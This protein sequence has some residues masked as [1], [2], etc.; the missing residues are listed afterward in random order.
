MTITDLMVLVDQTPASQAR[1]GAALG[2]A[3]RFG[4]HLTALCLVAEPFMRSMSRF[5]LPDEVIREH[6]RHAQAEADTV[7][8][9]VAAAAAARAVSFE[10]NCVVGPL[11]RLPTILAHNARNAD[12][13]IV[14]EPDSD[15]SGADEA[16]LVETAFMDTGR[17]ALVV[18]QAGARRL[19]PGRVL[20]AWDGSRE[21]ARAVH[22]GL[23]LLRA[24]EE[25]IVLIADVGR[26]D[27]RF[28]VQPGAGLVAHLG[29]HGVNACVKTVESGG[30]GMAD[31]IL[32]QAGDEQVDLIV[33][34]GYG[35]S[36]LREMMLG[37]VTRR[38]LERM[39]LPV[40]FA[41]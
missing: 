40:L 41:H 3:E 1:V 27:G 37:G 6:L 19:P 31:V 17:P 24:A 26:R 16:L 18:P 10:G 20:V 2:L 14:G 5:H 28:G 23:P 12:L 22:D 29:R 38:M 8:R 9:D 21:A 39:T 13:V 25:V 36:R 33:M 15:H 30:K 34:G 7:L 32:A 11:E 4:A 35:H